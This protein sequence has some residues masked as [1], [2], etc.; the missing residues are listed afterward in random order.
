MKKK[1]PIAVPRPVMEIP[2]Y[3]WSIAL[4]VAEHQKAWAIRTDKDEVWKKNACTISLEMLRDYLT[5]P[6]E[7]MA[8]KGY[9]YFKHR[10]K[11]RHG[12]KDGS[13]SD[14]KAYY[15]MKALAEGDGT[16][17]LQHYGVK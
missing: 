17:Y 1:Q 3:E 4:R 2:A 12:Y 7:E 11:L 6:V 9:E 8:R 10:A 14:P 15:M 16:L 13:I 5:Q